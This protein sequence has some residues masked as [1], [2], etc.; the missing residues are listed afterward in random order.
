MGFGMT[1]TPPTQEPA[2]TRFAPSPNGQLHLGHAYSAVF[3]HDIAKE[4][5]GAFLLR[6]EDIDGDRALPELIDQYRR[7]L[8]WLGL[9]WDEVPSQSGRLAKYDVAAQDLVARGLLYPCSCTRKEIQAIEPRIGG[10]G[11]S[12]PGSCK[13]QHHDPAKPAALR[14]DIDKAMREVGELVWTDEV[15]G[16]VIADPREFGDVVIVRKDVPASYHLAATLDDAADGVTLVTRGADL[17]SSTHIHRVLQEL[18]KLPV[19]HCH[20]HVLLLD[21]DG[22]KL[23]KRRGSPPL[24]ERRMRGDDGLMLAEQLRLHK[25]K[26]GNF[27]E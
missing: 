13:G 16:A 9:E 4:T 7:D 17:F 6:I 26:G 2:I 22:K 23:A 10:D 25:L 11:I 19:P 14:L 15:A 20:H 18:L 27:S 8:E 5:G 24:A 21:D 3:A 1:E 12:Y